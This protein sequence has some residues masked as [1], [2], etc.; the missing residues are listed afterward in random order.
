LGVTEY[1]IAQRR[2]SCTALLVGLMCK[3]HFSISGW[4]I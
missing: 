4:T 1:D 2:T 3:S